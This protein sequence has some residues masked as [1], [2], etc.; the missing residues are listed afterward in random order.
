MLRIAV[1]RLYFSGSAYMMSYFI[2]F[3]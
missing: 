2:H 1:L 3:V